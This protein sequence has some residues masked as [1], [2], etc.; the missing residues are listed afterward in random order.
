MAI[1]FVQQATNG[2]VVDGGTL[3]YGSNVGSGTLLL[4]TM[5]MQSSSLVNGITDALGNTWT[6]AVNKVGTS[7]GAGVGIGAEIWWAHC[8]T[9]GANTLTFD[10]SVAIGNQVWIGEYSGFTSGA[11]KDQ[12]NSTENDNTATN[13]CGSIT[14]TQNEEL[15]I[16]TLSFASAFVV[17]SRLSGWN[18]LTAGSRRDTQYKI[19]STT[20]TTDGAVTCNAAED[21][22]CCIASFYTAGATKP[23]LYRSHTRTLNAGFN[24]RIP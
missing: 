21:S 4:A 17:S 12:T 5:F 24:A 7:G 10:W 11:T 15:L 6:R 3:A 13:S 8:P 9:G 16:G 19:T 18:A 22:T 1:A 20:E 2:A 14:T 23:W